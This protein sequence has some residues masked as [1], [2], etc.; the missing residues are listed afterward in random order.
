MKKWLGL[1][2]VTFAFLLAGCGSSISKDDLKANDWVVEFADD[3]DTPNMIISFS[4]HVM[5]FKVDTS[6]IESSTE[7]EWEALGEEFAK[8]LFDQMNYK[9]EYELN[10]DELKVQ[11]DEDSKEYTYYKVSKEEKNII[12]APDKE[13]NSDNDAEKMILKPYKAVKDNTSSTDSSSTAISTES[14]S[15]KDLASGGELSNLSSELYGKAYTGTATKDDGSIT[16]FSISFNAFLPPEMDASGDILNI[17]LGGSSNEFYQNMTF[18]DTETGCQITADPV[19]AA[20]SEPLTIDIK[21]EG[22]QTIS[23]THSDIKVRAAYDS[24]YTQSLESINNADPV[25]SFEDNVFKTDRGTFTITGTQKFSSL[26][27]EQEGIFIEFDFEN[28]TDEL[29]TIQEIIWDYFDAI[30]TLDTTTETLQ[31]AMFDEDSPR[32]ERYHKTEVQVNP[33][34]TVQAGYG[35]VLVDSNYP[36]TVNFLDSDHEILASTNFE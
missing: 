32:Y 11:D 33:G 24:D 25:F 3:E 28:T 35:Y 34:A 8:E 12:L 6:S 1:I 23:F 31:Y 26:A 16:D 29:Q 18:T 27:D 10:K 7:N 9:L 5:S 30:Q 14:T 19:P 22:D 15:D 20:D 4:D 21:D 17:R 13:K 36:L 2:I